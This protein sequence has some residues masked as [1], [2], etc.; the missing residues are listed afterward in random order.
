MRPAVTVQLMADDLVAITEVG[1]ILGVS[2][3][4]ADVIS[5]TD[6]DFPNPADEGVRGRRRWRLWRRKDIE[7]YGKATGRV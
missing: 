3:Q 5:Q 6:P 1:R 7:R 2:K 4:R